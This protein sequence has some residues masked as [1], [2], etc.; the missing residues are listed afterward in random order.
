MFFQTEEFLNGLDYILPEIQKIPLYSNK[1]FNEKFFIDKKMYQNWPGCRSEELSRSNKFF[2]LHFTYL[3]N[4][5]A[6]LKNVSYDMEMYIHLRTKE[7]EYK[8]WIHTDDNN[9]LAGLLYLN[10]TNLESGTQFYTPN[11]EMVNDIKYVQNRLILYSGLYNH[12]GY[13]YYGSNPSDG[14]LTLNMF[15]TF[16]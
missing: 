16:K 2:A 11:K 12:K 5:L 3:L 8:D 10:P 13:G 15:I 1:Q 9:N 7:D 6:I 4:N 14:R